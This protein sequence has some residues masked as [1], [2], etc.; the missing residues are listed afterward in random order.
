MN[1]KRHERNIAKKIGGRRVLRGADFSK[2]AP[3]IEHHYFSVECKY[4]KKI[5]GFLE[6]GLKEAEK[7][8]TEKIPILV[9]QE[10]FRKRQ[11][12]VMWFDDFLRTIND[13]KEKDILKGGKV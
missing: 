9:I 2:S 12:V 4:R 11:I 1:W 3:D 6:K 5:S 13:A 7:Y 10:K 8:S